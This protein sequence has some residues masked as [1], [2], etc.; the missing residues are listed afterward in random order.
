MIRIGITYKAQTCSLSSSQKLT[1][2]HNPEPYEFSQL[3]STILFNIYFNISFLF[4]YRSPN[5]SHPLKFSGQNLALFYFPRSF[6]YPDNSLMSFTPTILDVEFSLWSTWSHIFIHLLLPHFQTFS[7]KLSHTVSQCYFLLPNTYFAIFRV[8]ES[9][10][11]NAARK[12]FIF[13]DIC[14]AFPSL[15]RQIR[16][17]T[18]YKYLGHELPFTHLL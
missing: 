7:S 18:R 10:H 11:Q 5:P 17:R 6:M 4:R 14:V 9:R 15:V 16:V 1:F 8:L 13:A 3:S 2:W 12:T